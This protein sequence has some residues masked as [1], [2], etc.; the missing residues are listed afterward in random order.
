MQFDDFQILHNRQIHGFNKLLVNNTNIENKVWQ[1]YVWVG[2]WVWIS[3][4][5]MTSTVPMVTK[6]PCGGKKRKKTVVKRD[7]IR[8]AIRDIA[9]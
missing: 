4:R 8:V 9:G 6:S 3:E 2:G 1:N 5:S 7:R